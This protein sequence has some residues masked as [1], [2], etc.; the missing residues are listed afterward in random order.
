MIGDPNVDIVELLSCSNNAWR[1]AFWQ[2]SPSSIEAVF[3]QLTYIKWG[4][5]YALILQDPVA[6]IPGSMSSIPTTQKALKI[7]GPGEIE[8]THCSLVPIPR[9]DEVLVRV[10][11]VAVN[12]VDGKS[13]DLSPTP[14]ATL[15]C[16]FSGELVSVGNTVKQDLSIYDRVCGCVFGN[17][18]EE[19]NNGAFAEYV[20]VPGDLIFKI[21]AA[22]SFQIAA[23]LGIGL[24]TVGMALYQTLK[25]PFPRT[26]IV[27]PGFVLVYGGGTATGAIAIQMIRM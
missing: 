15:G 2:K 14:G 26:Q 8:L 4:I 22:M 16:D 13:A 12:P 3:S 19:P 20:A 9:A 1:S 21:P 24:S 10:I 17:N 6:Y 5:S 27:K 18:S 23:S 11:C 25:L 7:R